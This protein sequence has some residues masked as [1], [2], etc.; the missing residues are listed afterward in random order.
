M[1]VLFIL[2]TLTISLF[3][4]TY[5][6]EYTYNASENDSKVSAR[7]AAMAQVKLLVIEEVGVRVR[8]TYFKKELV[9]NDKLTQTIKANLSSLGEV[10]SKTKILAQKWDGENFY[11]KVEI[12]VDD[13][14]LSKSLDSIFKEDPKVKCLATAKEVKHKLTNI[15]TPKKIDELVEFAIKIPYD[16]CNNW[17]YYIM[18]SFMYYEID[19]PKYKR[20]MLDTLN[21]NEQPSQTLKIVNYIMRYLRDSL[22][23]EDTE[24]I[25]NLM[26][27]MDNRN[28]IL[29]TNLY[30]VNKE[31]YLSLLKPI[32]QKIEDKEYGRPKA[33]NAD[34]IFFDISDTLKG[35]EFL[36]YYM[37][38]KHLMSKKM[39]EDKRMMNKIVQLYKSEK[40]SKALEIYVLY[41]KKQKHTKASI[42]Q[43]WKYISDMKW[44]AKN[45]AK[46]NLSV[47]D[48][49]NFL[50]ATK[51]WMIVSLQ[52]YPYK[53]MSRNRESMLKE[54][55]YPISWKK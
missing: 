25:V 53:Y 1:K 33:L 14:K 37:D 48:V 22:D 42:D 55:N 13:T 49:N 21:K 32:F 30:T 41:L 7:K 51:E 18:E 23:Q 10:M 17:H 8:S 15:S 54:L 5:V 20:F 27:R 47:S 6:K 16:K 39:Q 38:Y 4:Q 29:D 9:K 24:L 2:V 34:N 43:Y 52:N 28:N 40:S 36:E 26:A 3:S 11:I 46:A 35:E 19:A 50:D 45:K 12:E 31:F 44:I